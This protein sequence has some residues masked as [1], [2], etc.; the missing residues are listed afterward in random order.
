M[1]LLIALR[2]LSALHELPQDDALDNAARLAA[3]YLFDCICKRASARS[4]PAGYAN[5]LA[6]GESLVENLLHQVLERTAQ[7]NS[8]LAETMRSIINT[9]ERKKLFTPELRGRLRELLAA[10]V[11]DDIHNS[12]VNFGES[13]GVLD[14]A[15]G[16][17]HNRERADRATRQGP[18]N[19]VASVE[20]ARQSPFSF[21]PPRCCAPN[22]NCRLLCAPPSPFRTCR[23]P[24]QHPAVQHLQLLS[25]RCEEVP[26][27]GCSLLKHVLLRRPPS[28]GGAEDGRAQNSGGNSGTNQSPRVALA[29][30]AAEAESRPSRL[31]SSKLAQEEVRARGH[32]QVEPSDSAGVAAVSV[33]PIGTTAGCV[34]G[35]ASAPDAASMF[36]KAIE[37]NRAEAKRQKIEAR[38]RPRPLNT[39]EEFDAEWSSFQSP[40]EDEEFHL[41]VSTCFHFC[42]V[43]RPS[44]TRA[45]NVRHTSTHP[46]CICEP[47]RAVLNKQMRHGHSRCSRG[48]IT[49]LP[50][51][52]RLL[53]FLSAMVPNSIRI[54]SANRT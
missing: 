29:A 2:Y 32:V 23:C 48:A 46:P 6:A 13:E 45:C 47:I 15:E 36:M 12:N 4:E 30:L 33:D 39:D 9:W 24:L 54:F 52:C 34:A 11:E 16:V 43:S 28:N 14:G 25:P 31:S 19:G 50:F 7:A 35:N 38:L 44:H 8:A 18:V 17:A 42:L 53:L 49:I 37:Q 1:C 26:C 10:S 22:H 27:C 20:D 5:F 41:Q 3:L 21:S 40:R 51:R